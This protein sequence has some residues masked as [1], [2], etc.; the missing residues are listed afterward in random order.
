M[1]H[2]PIS[3]VIPCYNEIDRIS[4]MEQ[5]IKDFIE[6]WHGVYEVIIV[7]DGSK[8]YTYQAILDNLFF[9]KLITDG[10]FKIL[11]QENYGKGAALRNGVLTAEMDFILTLDADMATHPNELLQWYEINKG[12]KNNELLIGSR[13]LVTSQ[14]NDS[15]KRKFIGN[16]FNFFVRH[17]I[18]LNLKDTQCGFKL[19]PQQMGKKLFSGLQIKG[20]AHDVELLKKAQLLNYKIIEMPIAWNAV[21]G[22]KINVLRDSWNMFWEVI[23]I[24]KVIKNFKELLKS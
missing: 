10:H 1:L 21:E 15:I 2:P 19:Y 6:S 14:V 24:K 20:W 16:V 8:D 17:F 12:F 9:K 5:G 22:S 13:E 23:K 7:D 3:L 4:K 11:K 18:K